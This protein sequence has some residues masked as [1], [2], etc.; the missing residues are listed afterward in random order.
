MRDV[1]R[2]VGEWRKVCAQWVKSYASRA[3][4]SR[5]KVRYVSRLEVN[6]SREI[7]AFTSR[8]APRASFTFTWRLAKRSR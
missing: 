7:L 3:F 4:I 5:V 2:R 8:V 1:S 6:T